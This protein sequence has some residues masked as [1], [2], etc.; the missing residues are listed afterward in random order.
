MTKLRTCLLV[1][2]T[3]ILARTSCQAFLRE[4][5][6]YKDGKCHYL[7]KSYKHGEDIP[8]EQ[9][10]ATLTCHMKNSSLG[11]C[12][13]AIGAPSCAENWRQI[14]RARSQL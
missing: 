13:L 9:P 8:L 11:V 7:G 4:P 2:I 1:F 10:C 14:H 12:D 5:I 3:L 6:T